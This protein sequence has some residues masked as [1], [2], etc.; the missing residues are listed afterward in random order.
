MITNPVGC[1]PAPPK[2][3]RRQPLHQASISEIWSTS[4]ALAGIRQ[5]VT[6][7]P[8]RLRASGP[9]AHLLNFCP[10]AA[11]LAT[12]DAGAVYA[13]A[14]LRKEVLQEMAEAEARPR[15]RAR[16]PVVS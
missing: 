4:P 7:I 9:G 13:A 14:A 16:L 15:E 12:G 2:P 5:L 8:G 10:G 1:D 11:E 6:E 3:D